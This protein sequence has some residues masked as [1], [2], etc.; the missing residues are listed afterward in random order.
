VRASLTLIWEQWRQTWR[1][2]VLI[3]LALAGYWALLFLVEPLVF[4]V[5][6]NNSYIALAAAYVPVIGA[7]GLLFMQESRSEIGFTYPRRMYWLPVPTYALAGSQLLYKLVMIGAISFAAGWVC[8]TEI[9]YTLAIWPQT[10]LFLCVTAM[11][12]ALMFLTS[13]FGGGTGFALFVPI[14]FV[15]LIAF[16]PVYEAAHYNFT[17]IMPPSEGELARFGL[18]IETAP[19]GLIIWP[20][21]S[22][23][24]W[25]GGV[26]CIAFWAVVAYLAARHGR[27]EVP[28]DEVGR[29]M[30]RVTSV[31]YFERE[32]Q[33]F[34]SPAA[35]QRWFEWRRFVYLYPW[36][37][38][39]LG[40]TLALALRGSSDDDQNRFTI[41][42]SLFVI[43]PAVV[44]VIL[45]YTLTRPDPKYMWFVGGRPL[46]TRSITYARLIVSVKAI[47]VAYVLC[48]I[49]YAAI[50][51]MLNGE[52]NPIASLITDLQLMTST[53]GQEDAGILMLLGAACIMVSLIWTLFW[54]AR[55]AGVIAWFA[56]L[57]AAA[58]FGLSGQQFY[59]VTEDRNIVSPVWQIFGGTFVVMVVVGIVAVYAWALHRK[60]L[61]PAMA[62]VALGIATV[63]AWSLFQFREALGEDFAY[64][65]VWLAVPLTP[66]ASVPATLAW[67]RHR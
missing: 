40:T 66:L 51:A 4:V 8:M 63:L 32:A 59:A 50:N 28:R 13:A 46:T 20:T 35:A 41:A 19:D 56:G 27:S 38:V 10:L 48:G 3:L 39:A 14:A 6:A 64:A 9:K 17:L 54:L 45:G 65:F 57:L 62:P 2:L 5:F 15:S 36:L 16:A 42:L 61:G 24:A 58:F 25:W 34:G 33:A 18:T 52:P 55:S 11:L 22:V 30:R 37:S 49:V 26:A 53:Y 1:G 29:W 60:L 7:I 67:Q 47:A 21:F 43:A 23:W 44:A 12:C 31:A